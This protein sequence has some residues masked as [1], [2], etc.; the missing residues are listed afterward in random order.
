MYLLYASTKTNAN[1]K[2]ELLKMKKKILSMTLALC[3]VFGSA[4]VLAAGTAA[5]GYQ[6]AAS[7]LSE[8]MHIRPTKADSDRCSGQHLPGENAV[9]TTKAAVTP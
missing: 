9:T 7:S 5:A 4:A 6:K 3:L 2:K 8:Q 1:N